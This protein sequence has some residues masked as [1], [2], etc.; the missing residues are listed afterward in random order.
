MKIYFTLWTNQT[1]C[2]AYKLT[3]PGVE[4]LLRLTTKSSSTGPTPPTQFFT[5]VLMGE[6]FIRHHIEVFRK[7]QILWRWY[8]VKA[9]ATLTHDTAS[10]TSA[11]PGQPLQPEHQSRCGSQGTESTLG[12]PDSAALTTPRHRSEAAHECGLES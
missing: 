11:S 6:Q 3:I 7:L 1:N 8:I 4:A 10:K 2:P 12:I 5:I 9:V